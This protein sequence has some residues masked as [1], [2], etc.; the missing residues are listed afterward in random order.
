MKFVFT[1]LLCVIL[2]SCAIHY[3]TE[4]YEK[5]LNTLMG[6]SE[7]DLISIYGIPTKIYETDKAKFVTYYKEFNSYTVSNSDSYTDLYTNPYTKNNFLGTDTTSI[8]Q[9]YKEYCETM[10]TIVNDRVVKYTFKGN[11]CGEL[12]YKGESIGYF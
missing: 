8:S 1:L 10:F 7:T 11:K 5:Y 2:S 4:Y 9:H 6:I 3:T 12:V